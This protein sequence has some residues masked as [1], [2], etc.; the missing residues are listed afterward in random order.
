MENLSGL[1]FKRL[2]YPFLRYSQKYAQSFLA[3]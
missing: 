1:E 2:R 3:K